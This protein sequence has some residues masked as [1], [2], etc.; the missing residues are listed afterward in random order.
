MKG[1]VQQELKIARGD[2]VLLYSLKKD[3]RKL[4]PRGL[5]PYV[6][7]AITTGGAVRLETL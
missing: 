2:L 6:I 1:L 7:N 5:G 4:T 3:K